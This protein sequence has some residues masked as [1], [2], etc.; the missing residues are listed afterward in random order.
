MRTARIAVRTL[1]LSLTMGGAACDTTGPEPGP[2]AIKVGVILAE[3]GPASF[4]GGPERLVLE[5]LMTERAAASTSAPRVVL[6]YED[7]GGDPDR[8]RELFDAFAADSTVIAIIGPST[9]GES[10]PLAMHAEE[11]GLA[12]LSLGASKRIVVDEAG[13]VRPWAYHFAQSDDLA[14]T[15][16]AGVM[17]HEADT[18]VALLFSDDAFGTS[19]ADDFRTAA[20]LNGVRIAHDAAYQADLSDG[21]PVAANVPGS[22]AGIM[23]WGT[24]PGPALL[25]QA[26]GSAGHS[27][28][29]YLSHGDASQAFI[30]AAGAAA[31]G[32]IIVGSRVLYG[33][34]H[35]TP[36]D[37]RDD[38]ILAYH[39]LW[40][41]HASGSPSHFGGHAHDA[42]TALLAVVAQM[43]EGTSAATRR[44]F[45]RDGL[46]ALPELHGVTGTFDF[47]AADHGGLDAEAFGVF[48]IESAQFVPYEPSSAAA[49][50]MP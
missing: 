39:A 32:A 29:I 15:R 28:Q 10:I 4:I 6:E 30:D 46:E 27:A 25:V 11:A 1:A 16:L 47:T 2:Q 12:L 43:P 35:L 37:P 50:R 45:V 34:E 21:D 48:R 17:Q 40:S 8:A 20:D 14:A 9:S 13:D 19:G 41:E 38:V 44:H 49:P 22:V 5:A 18:N 33:A 23:I 3:T 31:H 26:L 24:A 36:G 42:L 7:S